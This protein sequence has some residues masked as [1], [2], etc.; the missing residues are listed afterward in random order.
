MV[1]L[2][3]KPETVLFTAPLFDAARRRLEQQHKCGRRW[4]NVRLGTSAIFLANAVLRELG[5]GFRN[6][7]IARLDPYYRGKGIFPTVGPYL[8]KGEGVL[9]ILSWED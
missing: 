6:T 8:Q 4:P 1:S 9:F 3:C 5:F 7:R 2:G